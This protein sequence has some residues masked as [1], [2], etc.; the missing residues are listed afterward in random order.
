MSKITIGDEIQ[1]KPDGFTVFIDGTVRDFI[2]KGKTWVVEDND[3]NI[4]KCKPH[5]V[6]IK[7]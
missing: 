6:K 2:K 1:M 3:G 7:K 4:H 5:Q